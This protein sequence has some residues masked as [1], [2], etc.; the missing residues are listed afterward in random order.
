MLTFSLSGSSRLYEV[1]KWRVLNLPLPWG[2]KGD[3]AISP[4]AQ[5]KPKLAHEAK[6]N[7]L[8]RDL[9]GQTLACSGHPLDLHNGAQAV[10]IHADAG[11]VGDS[12]IWR[13]STDAR[14]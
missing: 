8:P 1:K 6:G 4:R 9:W 14:V 11:W 13:G 3:E 10:M 7:Q 5:Q 12:L 2:N